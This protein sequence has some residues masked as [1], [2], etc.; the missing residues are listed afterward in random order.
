MPRATALSLPTR[1]V[2]PAII[3]TYLFQQRLSHAYISM[4]SDLLSLRAELKYFERVFKAENG[5]APSVD[6]IKNAGFADKYRLYKKLS[7]L[8]NATGSFRENPI[9]PPSTP[10]RSAPPK[11]EAPQ[12]IIPR[13]RAVKTVIV[14]GSN[15]FSPVKNKEKHAALSALDGSAN[16]FMT[17]RKAKQ[18]PFPPSKSLSPDPFP[19]IQTPIDPTHPLQESK[20]SNTVSRARKRLRGEPV[21]PSPVKEK[22]QRILPDTLP[23]PKMD[24]L[25]AEDSDDSD[26]AVAELA[27]SSFVA[28]SP[29]KRL[30]K[31]GAFKLLF[32]G[33]AG[34]VVTQEGP[35]RSRKVPSNSGLGLFGSKSQRARSMS[36]SSDSETLS[37][38]H[39][40]PEMK[41]SDGNSVK[42]GAKTRIE[43]CL[44]PNGP[45]SR[46]KNH[47]G[48]MELTEPKQVI[49]ADRTVGY[50][51][52]I[53]ATKPSL[54]DT[55]SDSRD[56]LCPNHRPALLPP[57]PP[58]AGS[59]SAHVGK[60]KAKGPIAK[61]TKVPE[62]S[63][64]EDEDGADVHV[65]IREWSWQLRKSSR[66]TDTLA[67]DLDP[68]LSF[69]A[70]DR[71]SSPGPMIDDTP[72]DI[73]INLPDDLR[74]LLAISPSKAQPT[75]DVGVVRGV[76]YGERTSNYDAQR[77]G[78]IWGVGEVDDANDS[79]A[80]DDWEGE[81]VPWETGEL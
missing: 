37:D 26:P 40:A 43:K 31:G 68:V 78:D 61:R 1:P 76:L 5:N 44:H 9:I 69:G 13:S 67:E 49:Q 62:D 33:G 16:P 74:R 51:Q 6:D 55:E 29:M 34:D 14:S 45:A 32:E 47:F 65:K 42:Y 57:S 52:D 63:G 72:G 80:E 28:D 8:G 59:S 23:F 64:C 73:V 79:Q 11:S 38:N 71:Q 75:R 41:A 12:S 22:R 48:A 60:R 15:P 19:P 35:S 2:C 3:P 7:K 20:Q 25:N 24:L 54:A 17:P 58:P 10:P 30:P 21:S 53:T 81:P 77:G 36:T 4:S 18:A 39:Q 70:H 56:T 27:D 46:K 66:A 50:S